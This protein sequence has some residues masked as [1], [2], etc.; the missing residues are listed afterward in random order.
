MCHW[1]RV[2]FSDCDFLKVP[3]KLWQVPCHRA[4]GELPRHDAWPSGI[5]PSPITLHNVNGRR[6]QISALGINTLD[7]S[8]R[9]VLA[10]RLQP[11]VVCVSLSAYRAGGIKT[12][13]KELAH[14]P[15]QCQQRACWHTRVL[16]TCASSV[17]RYVC[18]CT[19]SYRQKQTDKGMFGRSCQYSRKVEAKRSFLP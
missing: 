15:L 7:F 5:M 10:V 19:W 9:T 13:V 11:Q 12:E 1:F 14:K 16:H 4:F 6:N 2:V 3:V 8:K 17:R 18:V